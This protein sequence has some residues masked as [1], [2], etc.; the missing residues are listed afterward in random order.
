MV[1]YENMPIKHFDY[2]TLF[3]MSLSRTDYRTINDFCILKHYVNNTTF[4][5]RKNIYSKISFGIKTCFLCFIRNIKQR[6]I[7]KKSKNKF[8][9]SM[10]I[11]SHS[12][13]FCEDNL[14]GIGSSF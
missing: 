6:E 10:D 14:K 1:G 5:L 4:H 9:T 3:F 2:M 8:A 12:S 13:A 7:E 11:D